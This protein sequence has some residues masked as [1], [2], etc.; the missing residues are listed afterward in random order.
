MSHIAVSLPEVIAVLPAAG[1]GS[2]MQAECPKQYLSIGGKTLIEHSICALLQSGKV[3]QVIVALSPHDTQF[4]QLPIARDPRIRVVAGGAERAES[5]MAGLDVAGDSGW[6]LVHDAARPCLHPDDLHNLLAIA[7]T[8]KVGG[9]LAAP[10]RD[11]M[12]RGEPGITAI[13]HT[14]DRQ[15]L[16]HALTPQFF[17]LELLKTCLRRALNEG[18]VVTDEAS[19]MEYCGFH[20]MLIPARAD[21]IKVTRPEDLALAE[22]YLTRLSQEENA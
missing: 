4:E 20:P 19:A 1:I 22:F 11:T 10:V 5:V 6:V 12:K 13:A 9:I 21:N 16:W 3:S 17:P 8:S 2:R 15:D 14:V 18:A 7:T